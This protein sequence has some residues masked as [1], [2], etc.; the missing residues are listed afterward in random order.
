MKIILLSLLLVLNLLAETTKAPKITTCQL[1]KVIKNSWT[2]SNKTL[3]QAIIKL[4]KVEIPNIISKLNQ[5]LK[6]DENKSNIMPFPKFELTCND[7]IRLF[8][9][10]KYLESQHN[11]DDVIKV[12]IA[13]Y[14]GL[15]HIKM[16]SYMPFIYLIALNQEIS[17]SLNS[18]LSHGIFTKKEKDILHKKLSTLLVTDNKKLIDTLKAEKKIALDFANQITL[19]KE[20]SLFNKKI[21]TPFMKYYIASIKKENSANIKAI[22]TN[23]LKKREKNLKEKKRLHNQLKYKFSMW[24]L[25]VKLKLFNI[26]SLQA[27]TKEYKKLAHFMVDEQMLIETPALNRTYKDYNKMVES[28]KKLLERLSKR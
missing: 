2:D 21:Y 27:D 11:T 8:A 1:K 6:P 23:T 4:G 26:F 9:Y 7:Y 28:N 15:T 3:N 14:R 5:P 16:S 25:K 24:L 22:Q 18:S 10:T 12:Y 17:K 19:E 20:P 13:S